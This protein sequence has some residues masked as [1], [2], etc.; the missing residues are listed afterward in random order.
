MNGTTIPQ[1]RF[2]VKWL[3]AKKENLFKIKNLHD[4]SAIYFFL[5]AF[6]Y[7]AMILAFR[8]DFMGEFV[9]SLMRI[10]DIPFAFIALMYGG[11]T[12]ALQLNMDREEGTS[13]WVIVIFAGCL[14]LFAG[15]VFMNFA[16]PSNL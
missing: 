11:S 12:L 1:A 6:F 3:Q 7:V 8:N 15:V 13:P 2:L 4:I 9:L 16:F 14:L 10:L 5:L